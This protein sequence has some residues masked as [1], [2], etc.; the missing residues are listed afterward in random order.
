MEHNKKR[1][2][3][4][5]LIRDFVK[6]GGAEKY[7]VEITQRL[8]SEHEVHVF[9][10]SWNFDGKER[11]VFHR[12]PRFFIK[13]SILNQLIFSH[14]VRKA[15]KDTFDIIHSHERVTQFD[16]LTVHC[17]CFRAI[18]TR[19]GKPVR[20]MIAWISAILSPRKL[21]YLWL[22]RK[23][24]T[25]HKKRMIIA[26]SEYIK[27]DIQ[28]NY[29]LP[30]EYFGIAYPGV[31]NRLIHKE[32]NRRKRKKLRSELGIGEDDL[33]ILFV[34]TEFKRKGLDA[35]LEGFSLVHR[36]NLR[37]AIAGGGEKKR[38]LSLARRLGIEKDVIFLGLVE[39]I[40]DIYSISDIY[41]LPTLIDPAG[42]APLEAMASG[43]P[44]IM[45]CSE[46]A[47]IAE[48]INND[49]ALI[50]TNPKDP[51]E[52]ARSL[53]D[54]MNDTHRRELGN[55]GRRLASDL[56]WEKTTADTVSVYRRVMELKGCG[57]KIIE[58]NH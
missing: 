18:I 15:I 22:E 48:Q 35:L 51:S 4:A 53:L 23:Q 44:T 43:V 19:H 2:K 21:A 31:D 26:V 33:V 24:F 11:I 47:G 3:L 37:L 56:T 7:T 5:I 39:N 55:K 29:P 42:M 25:F 27:R 17:P 45:S 6:T 30:N 41:I 1:L 40:E 16:V 57:G 8:A 13:P 49:E 46:Y 20:R 12:I 28:E 36:Q 50:L 14:F 38:Y 9:A 52:I 32:N 54:L 34:G 58:K 10:Q